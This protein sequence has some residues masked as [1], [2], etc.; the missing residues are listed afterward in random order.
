M[1]ETTPA[2]ID[3]V[4]GGWKTDD[5]YMEVDW[6]EYG[7][8]IVMLDC[9][10]DSHNPETCGLAA[11]LHDVFSA[12]TVAAGFPVNRLRAGRTAVVWRHNPDSGAAEW[13]PRGWVEDGPPVQAATGT[14]RKDARWTR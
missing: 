1:P 14:G 8:P 6:T 13:A 4:A 7:T 5:H 2:G 9:P 3:V 11:V 10:D 12:D